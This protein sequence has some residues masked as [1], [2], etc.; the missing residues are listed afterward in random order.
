M[1]LYSK[2]ALVLYFAITVL[3]LSVGAVTEFV[4]EHYPIVKKAIFS[5]IG[6]QLRSFY[7]RSNNRYGRVSAI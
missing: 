2:F 7:T 5:F 3:L 4:K 6:K 1:K